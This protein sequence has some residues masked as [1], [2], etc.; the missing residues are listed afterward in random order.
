MTNILEQAASGREIAR[1][2]WEK[3]FKQGY[4]EGLDQGQ[5]EG[6][7]AL[8][9]AA[10]GEFTDMDDLA[11]RL[12]DRDRDRIARIVAGATLAEIRS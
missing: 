3:G 6:I 10:Y 11:R 8:L 7:R 2:N 5:V 1:R 4:I 12:L 9:R